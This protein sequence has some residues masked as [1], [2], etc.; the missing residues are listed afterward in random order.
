MGDNSWLSLLC[1]RTLSPKVSITY[2]AALAAGVHGL[3]LSK[4]K[5]AVLTNFALSLCQQICSPQMFDR[6]VSSLLFLQAQGHGLPLQSK[7]R[8]CILSA[9]LPIKLDMDSV[10]LHHKSAASRRALGAM[11]VQAK[12]AAVTVLQEE[13]SRAVQ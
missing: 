10:G 13:V 3:L 1:V 8:S 5:D 7:S 2:E 6:C 9:S 4:R 11:Q 12:V